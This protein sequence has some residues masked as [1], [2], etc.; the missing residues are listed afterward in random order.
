MPAPPVSVLV[1]SSK[2]GEKT[3][4]GTLKFLSLVRPPM[5]AYSLFLPQGGHNFTTWNRGAA[6]VAG[7][8]QRPASARDPADGDSS[9]DAAPEHIA[10]VKVQ[11]EV[12]AEAIPFGQ[13][14]REARR[15]S[16]P[17]PPYEGWPPCG[18]QPLSPATPPP[19][20]RPGQR[21]DP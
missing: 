17:A 20:R 15:G 5:R 6:A 4:P 10:E 13:P 9:G 16:E 8:A 12:E 21:P 1:A 2:I 18:C 11:V 14:P 7:M 19:R 3:Y